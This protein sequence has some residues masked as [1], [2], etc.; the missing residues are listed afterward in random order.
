M[1]DRETGDLF[2]FAAEEEAKRNAQEEKPAEI[3][4][5]VVSEEDE[6][7]RLSDEELAQMQPPTEENPSASFFD[8]YPEARRSANKA[9]EFFD[10]KLREKKQGKLD[11]GK[12]KKEEADK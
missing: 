1:R 9:R 2:K 7:P 11:F 3:Q 12:P 4:E 5:P 6:V 10:K 8:M